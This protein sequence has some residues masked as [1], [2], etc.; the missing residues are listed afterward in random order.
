MYVCHMPVCMYVCT[1]KV[2]PNCDVLLK[3]TSKNDKMHPKCDDLMKM[4]SK[5]DEMH[6]KCDDLTKMTS[7]A[8]K[9]IQTATTS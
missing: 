9:C 3:M 5:N 7:K 1:Q 4:T 6:P 8:S 2:F